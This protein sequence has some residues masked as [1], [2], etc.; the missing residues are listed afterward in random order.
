VFRD[1]FYSQK[2]DIA[3]N[4]LAKRELPEP[5]RAQSFP[6]RVALNQNPPSS[7]DSAITV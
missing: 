3:H 5:L 1:E 4:V 7:P 6:A 2:N